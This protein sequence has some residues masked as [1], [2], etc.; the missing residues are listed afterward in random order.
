MTAT[1]RQQPLCGSGAEAPTPKPA[2]QASHSGKR[3]T[4]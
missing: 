1:I 3:C 4:Q 2:T